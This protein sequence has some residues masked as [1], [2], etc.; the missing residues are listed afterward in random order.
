MNNHRIFI[1]IS[2]LLYIFSNG[3]NAQV[4]INEFMASNSVTL[5][6]P[7]YNEYGD[8]LELYNAGDVYADVGGHYLTDDLASLKKWKIPEGTVIPAN[9]YLI[10]WADDYSSVLHTNF[11]LSADGE[12]IGFVSPEGTVLDKIT[13]GTQITDVS[14]GRE[15]DG[16]SKWVFMD[17]PSPGAP[18][19]SASLKG[20]TPQPGVSVEGGF[21]SRHLSVSLIPDQPGDMIRYTL[22]GSEPTTNSYLYS[23]P[24]YI[25]RT[26]TLRA[27]SFRTDYLGS[28]AVNN[29]YFIYGTD[30]DLPVIS[31][32]TNPDSLYD[33]EEGIFT[34]YEREKEIPAGLE[35]FTPDGDRIF[36]VN[37]GIAIYGGKTR[38]YA[39]KALEVQ[40]RN[41]YGTEAIDYRFFR[42]NPRNRFSSLLLRN[43]GNDWTNTGSSLGS[44]YS[45]ALQHSLLENEMDLETSSYQ[46][47]VIYING[48][49][50][51]ILNIRE[52]QNREYFDYY[53]DID[54]GNLDIFRLSKGDESGDTIVVHEGDVDHYASLVSYLDSHD[55]SRDESYEYIKTQIDIKS[56]INYQI[57]E[58]FM[59]N[60]D[61]PDNNQKLWRPKQEGGKWR[62]VLFDMDF[63]FNCF[64][65]TTWP[66]WEAWRKDM[67]P[68]ANGI[69]N[70]HKHR[71]SYI[72]FK[73]LNENRKFV[74]EFVQ[75]YCHHLNTT[76]RSDRLTLFVDSLKGNIAGEMHRHIDRWSPYKGTTSYSAWENNLDKY[77]NFAKLRTS[78]MWEILKSYYDV[79]DTAF[80]VINN[81]NE[82]GT[83]CL[84]DVKIK[85][86]NY[87]G[88][89]FR[90]REI[91]LSALPN[92]GYSFKGWKIYESGNTFSLV[93]DNPLIFTPR[94]YNRIE[95]DYDAYQ[96]VR[97][98]EICASNQNGL[99]DEFGNNDDWIEIYNP[100]TSSMDIGGYY[101]TDNLE[102]KNKWKVPD[103]QPGTT[104]IPPGGFLVF[105]ADSQPEQGS[106]HT[107]FSLSTLGEEVGISRMFGTVLQLI[108][109]L[110]F[111]A[112]GQNISYGCVSDGVESYR[113]FETPTPG[114]SNDLHGNGLTAAGMKSFNI[115]IY[116]NPVHEALNIEV[117]GTKD[118]SVPV[119]IH[120][121]DVTGRI[122]M[123]EIMDDKKSLNRITI[124]TGHFE[125]GL[126]LLKVVQ[127][128]ISQTAKIV[129]AKN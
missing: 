16:G 74:D 78:N 69:S 26:I 24:L 5:N 28:Y 37:A 82:K 79:N 10:I 12:S 77:Y 55:M 85:P 21:F 83:V 44:M 56:F 29:T 81:H 4:Y 61:W 93:P 105:W 23:S 75:T 38:G 14:Y 17:T 100:N 59:A 104:T 126:Y 54:P 60:I 20:I 68:L 110:T 8:W 92:P 115:K 48:E 2:T 51:G 123:Q 124:H 46:P 63:G 96:E 35:Y 73:K 25:D 112:A 36:S 34:H 64:K 52:K 39:Q 40:F 114:K 66:V 7:D 62:W 58:N 53:F 113:I 99:T 125:A 103:N 107:N 86:E 49:Y 31:V 3:I 87:T 27:K 71:W 89:Y 45:D 128:N 119:M 106:L 122:V 43:S 101:L 67:F 108:D 30:H 84:Y 70:K 18:N 1:L 57:A 15:T 111:P 127:G 91:V 33:E 42:N 116:P 47:A 129:K 117:H 6:D 76:F 94:D 32:T 109:S 88:Y 98:N 90:D 41:R 72:I 65:N 120:L 50:W 11:K 102:V 118:D 9:A 80:L 19:S 95:A 97:I 121:Y 13:Y 22:D